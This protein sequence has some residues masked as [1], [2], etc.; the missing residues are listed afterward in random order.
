MSTLVWTSGLFATQDLSGLATISQKM[1]TVIASFLVAVETASKAYSDILSGYECGLAVG[2][3]HKACLWA[4]F[5]VHIPDSYTIW[6]WFRWP[7]TFQLLH[8]KVCNGVVCAH[9][10]AVLYASMPVWYLC[11]YGIYASMVYGG[12]LTLCT[13]IP[14]KQHAYNVQTSSVLLFQWMCYGLLLILACVLLQIWSY[15]QWAVYQAFPYTGKPVLRVCSCV[16]FVPVSNFTLWWRIL[17]ITEQIYS[18]GSGCFLSFVQLLLHPCIWCVVL[19]GK[20]V[21]IGNMTVT[22]PVCHLKINWL[23]VFI[24]KSLTLF[25]FKWQTGYV[26]PVII[27]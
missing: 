25:I 8:L 18:G 6:W 17:W 26:A 16:S 9:L 5:D 7:A 10:A 14:W 13:H 22:Y 12:Y 27:I 3:V 20:L 11:Q 21:S 19:W 23:S 4:D 1:S 2:R 24:L 15:L